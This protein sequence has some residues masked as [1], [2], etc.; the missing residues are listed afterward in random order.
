MKPRNQ[1]SPYDA[2]PVP[3]SLV[4]GCSSDPRVTRYG[5]ARR[6][7]Y[8]IHY[9]TSGA[10]TFNGHPVRAGQGFLIPPGLAEHY[11]PD[12]KDPWSYLWIISTDPAIEHYF[13]RHAADPETG[14]FSYRNVGIVES[15]A[16]RLASEPNS[17]HFSYT[18]ILEYF[19][20]IYNHCVSTAPK[21]EVPSDK[22]YFDFAVEY[23]GA[24]VSSPVT[25]EEVCQRLGISQAYL[26]RIF[27]KHVGC[28]PKQYILQT[29][30]L[31]AQL[32]LRESDLSV[33]EVGAAVGFSDVLS[34]S[35]FFSARTGCSPTEYRKRI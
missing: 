1:F 25:V 2:A 30:L 32:L 9:V 5:P 4:I 28:S 18:E 22:L 15:I 13:Q 29:K 8:L 11:Y 12:E 26:Y 24:S 35:R 16:T 23:V 6:N 27:R 7:M 33:S 19:L 3:Q 17:L 20:C 34:F 10:G 21:H 14:I 31:E